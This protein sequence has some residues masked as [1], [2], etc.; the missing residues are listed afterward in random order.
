MESNIKHDGGLVS[1]ICTQKIKA[2]KNIYPLIALHI[3]IF[4]PYNPDERI[5]YCCVRRD[6]VIFNTNVF[7]FDYN[8]RQ[9]KKIVFK[10]STLYFQEYNFF[11]NTK[12]QIEI[13]EV[14]N[15]ESVF[16]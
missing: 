14:E 9:R 5:V 8:E 10:S 2:N 16:I 11:F 12:N 7:F 13:N 6:G 3:Y 1:T 15:T 4:S